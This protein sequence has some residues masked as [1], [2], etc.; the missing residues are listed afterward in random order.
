MLSY[1]PSCCCVA[2][3]TVLTAAIPAPADRRRFVLD[4]LF[5]VSTAY[6]TAIN[7][8]LA[9]M[10]R[11]DASLGWLKPSA[12]GAVKGLSK[13]ATLFRFCS[14]DPTDLPRA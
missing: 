6:S 4:L 13:A 12:A 2:A 5:D 10:E 1:G 11:L 7:E 8:L 9:T 14:H 3:D